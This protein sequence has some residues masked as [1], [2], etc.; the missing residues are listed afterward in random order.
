M[1]IITTFLHISAL[2]V[3]SSGRALYIKDTIA[4]RK[5]HGMESFNIQSHKSGNHL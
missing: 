1:Y 5:I 2:I 3:P 4:K